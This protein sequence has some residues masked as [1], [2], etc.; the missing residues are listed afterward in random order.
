[1]TDAEEKGDDEEEAAVAIAKFQSK[2]ERGTKTPEYS[3]LP[4]E[5]EEVGVQAHAGAAAA[6]EAIARKRQ[7]MAVGTA[8]S[9][10]QVKGSSSP[11]DQ[12]VAVS[13]RTGNYVM[14]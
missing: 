1:M 11:R 12:L 6:A 4:P 2:G 5:E 7:Q 3:H 14:L 9:N 8:A 13:P 10:T